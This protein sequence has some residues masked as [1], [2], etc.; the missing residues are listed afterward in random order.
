MRLSPQ[1]H[2]Q[3][4]QVI[5][6]V[7]GNINSNPPTR[8][9]GGRHHLKDLQM[10]QELQLPPIQYECQTQ[11]SVLLHS[12]AVFILNYTQCNVLCRICG[13]IFCQLNLV[14]LPSWLS[15]P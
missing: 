3:V 13:I 7:G 8:F 12:C 9:L 2:T 6:V 11:S 4:V 10:G 1:R 15:V 14:D 5:L